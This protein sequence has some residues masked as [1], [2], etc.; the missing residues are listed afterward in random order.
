MRALIAMATLL[1][2]A[3]WAVETSQ[4]DTVDA[5]PVNLESADA[6]PGSGADAGANAASPGGLVVDAGAL[7]ASAGGPVIDAGRP[8][9]PWPFPF[10]VSPD[11]GLGPLAQSAGLEWTLLLDSVS[12]GSSQVSVATVQATQNV[13]V[14]P[15]RHDAAELAFVLSGSA[16]VRGT[17]RQWTSLGAHDAV[18][19]AAGT[20]HGYWL[21]GSPATPTRLLVAWVPTGPEQGLR[22]SAHRPAERPVAAAELR[23]PDPRAPQPV[24]VTE[25]ATP[26]LTIAA[27]KGRARL[28]LDALST[29][30]PAAALGLLRFEQG[31]VLPEH[32]HGSEAEVLH[33]LRGRGELTVEGRPHMLWPSS[34][35]HLPAG[36]RHSFRV[37]EGPF[38][39]VQVYVPGGPEQRFR[40]QAPNK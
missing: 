28:L 31:T 8:L 32:A 25:R 33:V 35:T 30:S 34:T 13:E 40:G 4:V 11:A 37:L 7:G 29:A 24:V 21:S 10:H 17:G 26:E 16:R 14:W 9:P 39:A 12:A 2:G 18:F 20:A 23:K 15:H 19:A 27:G 6:G 3:A 1:A 5:G 36:R 38:E 22:T